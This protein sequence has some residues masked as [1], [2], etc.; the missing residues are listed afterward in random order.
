ML[1]ENEWCVYQEDG[2]CQLQSIN[3]DAQGRCAQ[4]IQIDLRSDHLAACKKAAR[5]VLKNR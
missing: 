1:C 2:A 5:A 3:V 4:C